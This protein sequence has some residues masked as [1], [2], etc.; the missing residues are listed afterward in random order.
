M[1]SAG[2][3]ASEEGSP[4]RA[5]K[6]LTVLVDRVAS[7][8]VGSQSHASTQAE[9]EWW[10]G[11]AQYSTRGAVCFLTRAENE[12]VISKAVYPHLSQQRVKKLLETDVTAH[13]QVMD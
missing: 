9:H 4:W 7:T 12:T 2:D 1:G 11:I 5:L 10:V 8:R 13:E 6:T 3:R